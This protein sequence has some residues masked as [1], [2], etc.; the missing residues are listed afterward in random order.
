MKD[1]DTKY[2][3]KNKAKYVYKSRKG[4][5]INV[6]TVRQEVDQEVDKMTDTNGEINP[7]HDII[8]NKVERDDTILSQ[9]EHC[10]ILSNMVSYSLI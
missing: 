6:E 8:V 4:S 9:M 1:K 2:L 5:I 3:I 7:Y 10:S